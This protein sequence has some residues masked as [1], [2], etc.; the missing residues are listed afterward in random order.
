MWKEIFGN[1]KT[2]MYTHILANHVVDDW[3]YLNKNMGATNLEVV[4]GLNRLVKLF[5][6]MKN[7]RGKPLLQI[8]QAYLFTCHPWPSTILP[9]KK[10][11]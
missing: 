3:Q 7:N 5:S 9:P 1:L 8:F 6:H 11:N 2:T 4:E 10:I